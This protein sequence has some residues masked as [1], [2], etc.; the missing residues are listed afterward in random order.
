MVLG[1]LATLETI[2]GGLLQSPRSFAAEIDFPMLSRV[3]HSYKD[4]RATYVIEFCGVYSSS[5]LITSQMIP[6]ASQ[7]SLMQHSS[8]SMVH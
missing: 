3:M 5:S 8:F 6:I 7:T 1:H 4:S 2:I